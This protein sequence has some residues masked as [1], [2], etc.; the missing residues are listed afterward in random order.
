MAVAEIIGT[1]I[2]VMIM[3]IVA[4]LVV[5]GILIAGETV[6]NAQKDITLLNEARMQTSITLNKSEITYSNSNLSFS[7]TNDGNE[8]ISD[9]DNIDVYIDDG[10]AQSLQKYSY[11]NYNPPNSPDSGNWSFSHIDPDRIHPNQLDPG[12]KMW[13]LATVLP[14]GNQPSW[15]QVTTSNGV[16]AQTTYP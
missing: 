3:I 9:F 2:G 8:V 4:Y 5:G 1:A 10:S 15:F 7:V 11:Q 13:V 14:P 12:E 16:N 6:A